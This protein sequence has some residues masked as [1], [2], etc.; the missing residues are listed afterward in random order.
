MIKPV[1]PS[2]PLI[3]SCNHNTHNNTYYLFVRLAMVKLTLCEDFE[4]RKIEVFFHCQVF[5]L[6][7]DLYVNKY[8]F[9]TLLIMLEFS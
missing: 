9:F 1:F 6:F 4:D 3:K 2:Y 8:M 7:I 5:T